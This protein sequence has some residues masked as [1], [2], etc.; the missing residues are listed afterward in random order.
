MRAEVVHTT[1]RIKDWKRKSLLALILVFCA[2]LVSACAPRGPRPPPRPAFLTHEIVYR[3]ETLSIIAAWYTG[4]SQNWRDIAAVNPEIN[5][6]KL[7]PGMEIRIPRALVVKEDYLPKSFVDAAVARLRTAAP[8]K[9]AEDTVSQTPQAL[10][11]PTQPQVIPPLVE[12]AARGAA[13]PQVP[14]GATPTLPD[15]TQATGGSAA[16][17][18]QVSPS[19]S[20]AA[21]AAGATAPA[22]DADR[23]KTRDQLLKELLQ[24]Y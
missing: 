20:S 1:T 11:P 13:V 4:S 23:Q 9:S 15:P 6:H 19:V 10:A 21:P 3:G 24:E 14:S 18:A 8:E 7:K 12:D 5:P 17:S 16:G 2:A 22:Q